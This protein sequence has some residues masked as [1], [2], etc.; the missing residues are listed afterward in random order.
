MLSKELKTKA[1]KAASLYIEMRG[2]K[3][4]E[5]NWSLGRS[6]IDI[7][8]IK[9]SKVHFIEV[10]VQSTRGDRDTYLSQAKLNKI[11]NAVDSWLQEN[12]SATSYAYSS[13]ILDETMTILSFN[14]DLAY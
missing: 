13:V 14:E 6:R 4:L 3:I 10:D 2:H 12:K 7:V 9:N 1:V 8:S 5:Q 11:K